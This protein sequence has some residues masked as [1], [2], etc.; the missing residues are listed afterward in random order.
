MSDEIVL[1]EPMAYLNTDCIGE[2]YLCFS[3]PTGGVTEN[4]YTADQLRAAV[5]ADRERRAQPAPGATQ[6]SAEPVAWLHD[7][8]AR[9]D[10][11]HTAVKDLLQKAGGHIHRPLDKTERYTIPLFTH[12][13]PADEAVRRDAERYRWLCEDHGDSAVR[14]RRNKLLENFSVRSYSANSADIDAAIAAA[15]QQ[16]PP[17]DHRD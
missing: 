8:S 14:R 1:P 11:I 10:V 2:R 12:P 6:P 13:A 3:A 17:H 15:Q 16:E 4:L 7:D 9:V 5:L